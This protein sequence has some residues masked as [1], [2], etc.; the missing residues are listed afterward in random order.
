MALLKVENLVTDFKTDQGIV[1]AV[2]DV[3]FEV[4]PGEVLGIVGESGSGKRQTMFS[5][6]GLLADNAL[7]VQGKITFDG[8]D[9]SPVS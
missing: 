1:H 2:R 7:P 5:I 3:S 9:I 8:A 6:M 4:N